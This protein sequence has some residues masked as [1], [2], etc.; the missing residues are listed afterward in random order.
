MDATTATF[1]AAPLDRLARVV[2]AFV[3]GLAAVF[4]VAGVVMIEAGTAWVAGLVMLVVGVLLAAMSWSYRLR[5]PLSYAIEDR[6]VSIGRRSA[7]PRR[8]EGPVTRARRGALGWRV[9]GDGGVY[10]YLGRF[11]AEG[12][13]VH[14]F[15]TDRTRVV[16]LEV[17][18]T[19]LAISPADPD[20]FVVE[21]GRGP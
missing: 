10:G 7:S 1:P 3:W 15:V 19:G 12:K 4:V 16:L 9:A 21:V 5:E 20:S 18:D 8:F 2:T 14:A 17:G 11:R 13:T 6:A